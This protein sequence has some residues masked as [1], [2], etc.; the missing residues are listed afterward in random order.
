MNEKG[1]SIAVL[2]LDGEPTRQVTGKPVI[3]TTLAIRLVLDQAATT[4]EAVRLLEDYDMSATGK[5]DYHFYI[6]DAKG[7]G[8]IIE[9]DCH[10]KARRLVATP[11]C[12]AT[13][14]FELYKDKALPNQRNGIYGHGRERYDIIEKILAERKGRYTPETA[15]QA[16]QMAAQVPKEGDVTSNTQWSVV[17]NDTKLT[18][19]IAV[20]RDWS[21]ITRYDLKSDH[22]FQ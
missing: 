19:E 3:T 21:T 11:V 18:A 20:R 10:D 16:L 1:V 15:W 2:T 13:N 5:R 14:F 7:D 4:A 9:F 12:A 8:R 17:Y 22:F 6:T